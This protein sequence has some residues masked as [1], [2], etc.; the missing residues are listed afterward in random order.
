MP[1]R[2]GASRVRGED[3]RWTEVPDPMH[4]EPWLREVEQSAM[5]KW[6]VIP[7][8]VIVMMVAFVVWLILVT[9]RDSHGRRAP[10]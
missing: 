2:L 8:L 4:S 9:L 7:A 10:R 1:P 6:D 5:T 3:E